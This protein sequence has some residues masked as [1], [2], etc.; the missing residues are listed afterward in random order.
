MSEEVEPK[1]DFSK[2]EFV[3]AVTHFYRGEMNRANVWRTRLDVTTNWA[4][5]T[6]A[7][8]LSFGFGSKEI[9]H[10]VII[11]A[12]IFV[13]FFLIIEA[14]R[15]K[16]FDLWR[17][18]VALVSEN[19]FAMVFS[20]KKR[21]F[22]EN[23]RELLSND[24]Q[25]P[26]FKMSFTEAFGRRLRRNYS[27]IFVV[28]AFCWITKVSIHP[29][30]VTH[31]SEIFERAAV[32]HILPGWLVISVGV[33]FNVALLIVAILSLKPRAEDVRIYPSKKSKIKMT[34]I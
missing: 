24:L 15:Y 7:A 27:W 22:Y 5:I 10:F 18:R 26:R 31:F 2:S 20:P 34:N 23:W 3:T 29:T 4:I 14:R 21:P 12:T 8:F 25:H 11:L 9:P 30:P 1:L 17:W 28:L 32:Y 13:L 19:F 33:V 16:Y 6:T